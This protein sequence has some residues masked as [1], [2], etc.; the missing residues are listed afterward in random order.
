MSLSNHATRHWNADFSFVRSV[1]RDYF[2]RNGDGF[3]L[4]Y[5]INLRDSFKEMP[6]FWE[7]ISRAKDADSFPAILVGNKCDL[8]FERRVLRDGK[9]FAVLESNLC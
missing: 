3:L 2:M 1:F 8:E 9:V 4:V 6:S 7:R 5:S